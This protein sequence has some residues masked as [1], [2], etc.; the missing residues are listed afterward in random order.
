[1]GG[2]AV[3]AESCLDFSCVLFFWIVW[4]GGDPWT[5]TILRCFSFSFFFY[6]SWTFDVEPVE[7]GF[8]ILLT[9]LL[10][11]FHQLFAVKMGWN[12]VFNSV[13]LSLWK[14]VVAKWK[15]KGNANLWKRLNR[16]KHSCLCEIHPTILRDLDQWLYFIPPITVICIRTLICKTPKN[17]LIW[18]DI[19]LIGAQIQWCS[20]TL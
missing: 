1:M 11:E 8:N 2:S 9:L 4:I 6:F 15:T 16:N 13:E 7:L 3:L 12:L 14:I 19:V 18:L 10:L 5:W 20:M 17:T